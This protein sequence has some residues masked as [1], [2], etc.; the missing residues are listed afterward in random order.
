MDEVSSWRD[1]VAHQHRERLVR[2]LGV[3]YLHAQ[4]G[5]LLRVHR[6]FPQLLGVHL[7]QPLVALDAHVAPPLELNH[8]ALALALAVGVVRIAPRRDLVQRRLGY[9]Q[10]PALDQL[11]HVA[12]EEGEDERPNVRAVHVGV[13]HDDDAVVAQPR[14]V[15][16]VVH[17]RA[18]GGD[19]RAD[20][21]VAQHLV[22]ARLLDVEYLAPQ[23]QNRLRAAVAPAL[24]RAAG[25]VALDQIQL[26]QLR[27]L[28]GAV[29]E[30]AGQPAAVHRVLADYQVARLP[31][32]LA[33]ALRRQALLDYLL[34]VRRVVLQVE[35]HR[36]RHHALDLRPHLRIAQLALRLPLELRL[37]ELDAHHR[38]QPFAR[39]F[40]R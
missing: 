10:I 32:R 2:A 33:R 34:G 36:L 30:L 20:A 5:S 12:E 39:L 9:V 27:V 15:E 18:D 40:A 31:R 24:R 14:E 16:V 17:A 29:G 4:Q 6:G 35:L 19:H 22:G 7:A 38:R 3:V 1:H 26:A 23:R 11:A 13:G 37:G 21:V 28:L 8:D 25:G